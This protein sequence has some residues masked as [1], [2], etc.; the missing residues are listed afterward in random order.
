MGY[1]TLMPDQP[2]LWNI[3]MGVVVTLVYV[4]GTIF[5]F[6]DITER[7]RFAESEIGVFET[8]C[9][10]LFLPVNPFNRFTASFLC[11]WLR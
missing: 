11:A 4:K 7:Y 6:A 3:I 8:I 5:L 2:L 10:E 9:D 1:I